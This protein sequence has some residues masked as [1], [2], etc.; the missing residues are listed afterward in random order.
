MKQTEKI[1]HEPF[2]RIVKRDSLSLKKKALVYA[3]SEKHHPLLLFLGKLLG[4]DNVI[5]I[6]L[7][8]AMIKVAVKPYLKLFLNAVDGLGYVYPFPF[9]RLRLSFLRRAFSLY[10]HFRAVE[11]LVL[12]IPIVVFVVHYFLPI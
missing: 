12:P 8:T 5:F 4:K 2:I 3:S 11:L 9:R 1:Q 7:P 6:K 10:S